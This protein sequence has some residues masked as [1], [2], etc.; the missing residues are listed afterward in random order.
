MLQYTFEKVDK[1]LLQLTLQK[2]WGVGSI[3]KRKIVCF[4]YVVHNFSIL[5]HICKSSNPHKLTEVTLRFYHGEKNV[6]ELHPMY[7]VI[8][9][10]FQSVQLGNIL[11]NFSKYY[12][13][14][15]KY[16][17]GSQAEVACL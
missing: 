13:H 15:K 11:S 14:F 10:I 16:R 3:E 4:M 12:H 6:T 7:H 5:S 9:R 2:K 17:A 8:S 1:N